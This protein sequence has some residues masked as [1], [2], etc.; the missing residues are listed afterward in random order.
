MMVQ[1]MITAR[2]LELSR[3]F[4]LAYIRDYLWISEDERITLKFRVIP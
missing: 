4:T 2:C 3:A 1:I